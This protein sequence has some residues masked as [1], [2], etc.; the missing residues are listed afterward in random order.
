MVIAEKIE[1]EDEILASGGFSDVRG[2]IYKGHRVA[3]KTLR[4][5]S[6]DDVRKIRKVSIND[7]SPPPDERLSN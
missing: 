1:V 2:G 6:R 5:A 3:V 4:V 7:I